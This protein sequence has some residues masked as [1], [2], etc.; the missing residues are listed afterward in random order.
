M[1]NI[2]LSKLSIV[3]LAAL[4][5]IG[6]YYFIGKMIILLMP[7]IIG[8]LISKLINPAVTL[9]HKK[10]R[11]PRGISTLILL[12]GVIFGIGLGAVT[13]AGRIAQELIGLSSQFPI[14]S[15]SMVDYMQNV[16]SSLENLR[17]GLPG[18]VSSYIST[19]MQSIMSRLGEASTI[20]GSTMLAAVTS[21]PNILFFIVIM[22]VS[23]FFMT[24]DKERIDKW[25]QPIIAGEWT[26]D[27][28]VSIIKRDVLGVLWGYLKAQLILM[29]LTFVESAIGLMII[30][31]NYPV[32]I[33][34]GIAL[35]DAL[36]ILGP[37]TIYI[38]WIITKLVIGEYGVAASLFILYLVV[39]LARQA[40]E[41]KFLSTQIG[42]YPLVTL[43]SMYIGLRTIGFAGIILGPVTVI[44][45][46]SLFKTGLLPTPRFIE[47]NSTKSEN[48]SA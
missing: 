20:V 30:G 41:P 28:K 40:L 47:Q 16:A 45:I 4:M 3:I 43:L 24:K 46:L 34:F 39:T 44:I 38:P 33:A 32:P 31:V 42:I 36:P 12:F 27:E 18:T 25:L 21:V 26:K 11:V 23:A 13:L 1:S 48:N 22:F 15:A 17:F 6:G 29:S 19:G 37:A 2:V 8:L 10:L 5:I 14:W 35:I 7:F 9:L